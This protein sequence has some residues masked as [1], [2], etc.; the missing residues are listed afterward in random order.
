MATMAVT[1]AAN[2]KRRNQARGSGTG[3]LF[4][5]DAKQEKRDGFQ[6]IESK[7]LA[8]S[9]HIRR[10]SACQ[11]HGTCGGRGWGRAAQATY[12]E[13]TTK[14]WECGEGGKAG[15]RSRPPDSV[16]NRLS[17]RNRR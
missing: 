10:W 16:K 3:S 7:M 5:N 17:V 2:A 4:F 11:P 9:G 12:P 8:P 1:S 14:A 13:I 6:G 15:A